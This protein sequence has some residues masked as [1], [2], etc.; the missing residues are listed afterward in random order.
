LK[1]EKWKCKRWKKN[2]LYKIYI[3]CLRVRQL[4]TNKITNP[5]TIH[6][7]YLM[8]TNHSNKLAMYKRVSAWLKVNLAALAL[9]VPALA[10]A[11][12]RLEQAIADILSSETERDNTATGKLKVR[13]ETD[14][15]LVELLLPVCG[16]LTAY[17]SATKNTELF[18]KAKTKKSALYRLRDNDLLI[19]AKSLAALAQES[20]AN[21]ADYAVSAET[22]TALQTAITN[23]E[24]AVADVGSSTANRTG[25][26]IAVYD[27]FDTADNLLKNQ[28]DQ[29][30]ES[31]KKTNVQLF[32]EYLAARVI[33]DLGGPRSSKSTAPAA[34]QTGTAATPKA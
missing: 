8:K 6:E 7:S 17:A 3:I 20:L 33:N 18:E 31:V 10:K 34:V 30:M 23:F 14:N 16:A 2:I 32:N 24:A 12:A 9:L 13:D 22:L 15:V 25:A 26:R 28:I 4:Y 19:K 29:L 1:T 5:I 27:G 21:L 11:A